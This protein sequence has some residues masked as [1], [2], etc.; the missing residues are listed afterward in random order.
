MIKVSIKNLKPGH[1]L[2]R[3]VVRPDGVTLIPAGKKLGASEI[4]LLE[5]LDIQFVLIEG[6]AFTDAGERERYLSRE[7]KALE[8]RFSRVENDSILMAIK[9]IFRKN[10]RQRIF[11]E[12]TFAQAPS[13]GKG[14]PGHD[15]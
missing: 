1:T 14:R 13:S 12:D 7:K 9:E 2:A 3:D 10:L 8:L 5:R 15:G 11:D 6:E 4:R